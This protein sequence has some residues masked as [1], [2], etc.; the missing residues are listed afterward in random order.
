M[1]CHTRHT[2]LFHKFIFRILDGKSS[3]L[4]IF[5]LEKTTLI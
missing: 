2:L 3:S 1:T 5:E 4:S